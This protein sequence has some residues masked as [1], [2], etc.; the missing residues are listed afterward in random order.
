MVGMYC[1]CGGI[2]MEDNLL[3][4]VVESIATKEREIID[5]FCKAF[6]AHKSLEGVSIKDIFNQY[7][8]CTNPFGEGTKRHWFERKNDIKNTF[9]IEHAKHMIENFL[10]YCFKSAECSL[11]PEDFHGKESKLIDDFLEV[12]RKDNSCQCEINKEEDE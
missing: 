6:M 10:K 2:L 3:Q 11:Y 7:T 1:A 12:Y 9:F 5:E 4:K 8:L